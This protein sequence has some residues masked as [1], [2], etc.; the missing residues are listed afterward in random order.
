MLALFKSL[1]SKIKLRKFDCSEDYTGLIECLKGHIRKLVK[2]ANKHTIFMGSD[3]DCDDDA[4]EYLEHDFSGTRTEFDS[5][6]G[7][8]Y[9]RKNFVKEIYNRFNL[10]SLAGGGFSQAKQKY[11]E[12]R[13]TIRSQDVKDYLIKKADQLEKSDFLNYSVKVI[14]N[15]LIDE[16][17]PSDS[18][19]VNVGLVK[20]DQKDSS[21]EN[22]NSAMNKPLPPKVAYVL[23]KISE[24]PWGVESEFVD[25]LNA[26]KRIGKLSSNI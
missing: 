20:K 3:C 25:D 10:M 4:N 6:T 23:D 22:S 12:E 8:K 18:E 2:A 21:D 13:K 17:N 15:K 16:K 11:I 1:Y 7:N 19:S 24:E 5:R 9:T 14:M 26:S